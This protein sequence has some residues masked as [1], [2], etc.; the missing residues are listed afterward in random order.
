MVRL[1]KV[2]VGTIVW[3]YIITKGKPF[4]VTTVIWRGDKYI[5]A[6]FG[7]VS[8]YVANQ[9]IEHF[10]VTKSVSSFNRL[11]K[12][13]VAE[14][15][16]SVVRKV[17]G[18]RVGKV[19]SWE[20]PKQELLERLK[21]DRESCGLVD[22]LLNKKPQKKGPKNIDTL[23]LNELNNELSQN[24]QRR[25]LLEERKRVIMRQMILEILQDQLDLTEREVIEYLR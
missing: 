19:Y 4:R 14:G 7:L 11:I 13:L 3:L 15:T 25:E 24:A 1:K 9:E 2:S 6:N 5:D 8:E 12:I 20:L 22:S 16:L 10:P 18:I 17:N 23:T 21:L